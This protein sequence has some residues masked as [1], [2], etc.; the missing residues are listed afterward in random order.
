MISAISTSV[1]RKGIP[2][3]WEGGGGYT[4]TGKS[5]IIANEDGSPATPIYIR[6]SG[7]LACATDHALFAISVGMIVVHTQ[8]HRGDFRI[9][10]SRISAILNVEPTETGR[11]NS[12]AMLTP[13]FTFEK[14]EWDVELP[15]HL[16]P[17]VEAAKKKALTYH[18]RQPIWFRD[19]AAS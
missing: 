17:V 10:V 15:E 8:Q 3:L 7:E 9:T 16:V 11:N 6:Q 4:S 14:G 5:Q 12:Q 19:V 18:C 13:L 1:T 2:A